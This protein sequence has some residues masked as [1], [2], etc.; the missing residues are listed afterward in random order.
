[1]LKRI[2]YIEYL[3]GWKISHRG[4]AFKGCTPVC[5]DEW[6]MCEFEE[7]VVHQ[8]D[9]PNLTPLQKYVVEREQERRSRTIDK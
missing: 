6:E 1:M 9:Y 2:M 8:E 5:F 3:I 7:M 4:K